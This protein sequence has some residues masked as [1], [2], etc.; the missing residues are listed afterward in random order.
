MAVSSRAAVG[1][2]A[3][4]A[5]SGCGHSRAGERSLAALSMESKL[6][7]IEAENDLFAAVDAVDE[8]SS[9]VRE[10]REECEKGDERYRAAQEALKL[11]RGAKDKTYLE[12]AQLSLQESKERRAWL[13]AWLA[14]QRK[15]LEA[16]KAKLE[17]ARCRYERTEVQ[18]VKKARV[19]NAEKVDLTYF[20][21]RIKNLEADAKRATDRAQKEAE[22]AEKA[23]NVWSATQRAL[24]KKTGGG[25]GSPWVE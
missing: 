12:I 11:A 15:L 1:L 18:L 14:V 16:E 10:T 5:L 25:Q 9:R 3:F 7:L 22:S 21:A 17:L 4:A 13:D 8:A 20:D 23:K 19:A 2:L 6:N 24:S